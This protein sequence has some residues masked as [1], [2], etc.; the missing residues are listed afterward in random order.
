MNRWV[1][2]LRYLPMIMQAYADAQTESRLQ[3][4]LQ[5][6]TSLQQQKTA[7]LPAV[8][9]AQQRGKMRPLVA[10][11]RFSSAPDKRLRERAGARTAIAQDSLPLQTN[12]WRQVLRELRATRI[13]LQDLE[14]IREQLSTLEQ[15]IAKGKLNQSKG[16]H[17]AEINGAVL[18]V[19]QPAEQAPGE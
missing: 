8:K 19:E 3:Q 13:K 6:G 12:A 4:E 14:R 11:H 10:P 9:R 17:D 7:A 1:G 16:V 15:Q 18:P 5:P 2:R